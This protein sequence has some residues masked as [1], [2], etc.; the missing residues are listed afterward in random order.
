LV[1]PYWPP[2]GR[3]RIDEDDLTLPRGDERQELLHQQVDRADVRD[4]QPIE[5]LH[6]HLGDRPL[7]EL[8]RGENEQVE[9]T[10]P[11]A[12]GPRQV[13]DVGVD[14]QVLRPERGRG[15]AGRELL[16]R[17]L[18]LAARAA[19]EVDRRALG[20]QRGGD[21]A[22]D[23]AAGAGHQGHL[24]PE[25]TADGGRRE[26]LVVGAAHRRDAPSDG[27]LRQ[28]ALRPRS[29]RGVASAAPRVW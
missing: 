20:R 21:R 22:P 15:G 14:A 4:P 18:E 28:L 19:D 9:A 5:D 24:P 26:R 1:A 29:R 23:A 17:R 7:N 25:S 6:R 10:A 12:K 8:A 2:P 27:L 13:L 16:R 3:A 11:V